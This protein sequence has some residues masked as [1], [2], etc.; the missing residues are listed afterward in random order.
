MLSE[1]GA[2]IAVRI[3]LSDRF[4]FSAHDKYPMAL[5]FACLNSVDRTV[6]F[7]AQGDVT[8]TIGVG[9]NGGTAIQGPAPSLCPMGGSSWS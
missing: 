8:Y 3:E 4:A 5:M 9:R 2:C 6:R 1:S 7:V